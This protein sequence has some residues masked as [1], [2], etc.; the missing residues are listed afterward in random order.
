MLLYYLTKLRH[1]RYKF[2]NSR[3]ET[4]L[5]FSTTHAFAFHIEVRVLILKETLA[6]SFFKGIH[7][8]SVTP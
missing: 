4:V 7:P 3:S 2:S 6:F 1:L 8:N 5:R